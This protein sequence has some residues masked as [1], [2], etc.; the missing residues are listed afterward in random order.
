[1]H[2]PSASKTTYRLMQCHR[3]VQ[4]GMS[5]VYL[6]YNVLRSYCGLSLTESWAGTCGTG[7]HTRT[8]VNPKG[9]LLIIKHNSTTASLQKSHVPKTT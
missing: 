5:K 4:D 7:C 6:P 9:V 1:M 3:A 8:P 2:V